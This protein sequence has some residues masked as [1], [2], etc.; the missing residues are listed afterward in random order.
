MIVS[1]QIPHFYAAVEQAEAQCAGEPLIVGGDPGKGAAV[2]SASVEAR[3]F[4]IEPG[5]TIDRA[6]ELCP[7]V[8]RCRTRMRTYREASATLRALLRERTSRIEPVGLDAFYLELPTGAAPI[9]FVADVCFRIKSELGL[10]AHAGIG[11]TRFVAHLAGRFPGESGLRHVA[12]EHAVEFLGPFPVSEIWGLGP[13]TAEKLARAGIV[14][15]VDLQKRRIPELAAIVG[16]RNALAF[17]Q[18][19]TARDPS[20]L[21]PLPRTKSLSRECTLPAPSADLRVLGEALSELAQGLEALLERERQT[22]RTLSLGV[23]YVEGDRCTRTHTV[24]RALTHQLELAEVAGQLLTRTQA[25]QR[26]VR[27]LSLKATK[28][29]RREAA[30]D[31]RQ[32]RLF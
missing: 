24:D 12:A 4:G 30:R 25:G 26:V 29:S 22:T 5:M 9:D 14:H 16:Q 13:V 11:P 27:K 23:A 32:L 21:S 15:I 8:R 1:I 10:D 19:A 17:Q 28:L 18:Y 2:R 3:A 6:L 7:Q 31:P 20:R